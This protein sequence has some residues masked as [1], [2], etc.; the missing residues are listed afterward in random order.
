MVA[1]AQ[2]FPLGDAHMKL[3]TILVA[4]AALFS[5]GAQ[6]QMG[7]PI[8]DEC[9]QLE[10]MTGTWTGKAKYSFMGEESEGPANIT[11]KM[12]LNGRYLEGHHD[13]EVPD[14]GKHFGLQM[15]TFDKAK[16]EWL[17]YW[18]DSAGAGAL[19]MRGKKEGDWYVLTGKYSAEGMEME[20]RYRAKVSGSAMSMIL[21]MKMGDAWSPMMTIEYKK[22]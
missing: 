11:A 7:E 3:K 6:A 5:L 14:M 16:G 17:S 1:K 19:E 2:P 21:E 18:F 20:M 15:M 22:S 9:K 12:S 4:C 10:A 8:P 13:Y